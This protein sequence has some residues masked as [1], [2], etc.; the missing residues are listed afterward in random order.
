M[1]Y[2]RIR[3]RV[4]RD[5]CDALTDALEQQNA[6][7]VSIE[8]AGDTPHYDA[9]GCTDPDWQQVTVTGLFPDSVDPAAIERKL[10]DCELTMDASPQID[11]LDEQDWQQVFMTQVEPIQI[12]EQLWIC[13]S[14][15]TPPAPQAT[16]IVLDPG[17]GFGTG[18]HATTALCLQWLA[19]AELAGK[20]VLDYGC[21]SGI[22]ALAAAKL[23]A[24]RVIALDIDPH[25]IRAT[26][27]NVTR[28][29]L[30]EDR[31]QVMTPPELAIDTQG[32]VII[33][34]ILA[35]TLVELAAELS[36]RLTANGTILLTG[37]LNS[38]MVRVRQAYE[39][40]FE[41]I[42]AHREEWC[43]LVG[44]RR[45]GIPVPEYYA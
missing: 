1:A 35:D 17:M 4:A 28:N 31:V 5:Q 24:A 38:Q 39:P 40:N 16:N 20:T 36:G 6:L 26:R 32:D 3:Y 25:A 30:A 34:N 19:Q 41:F 11:T 13:P 18:S 8:D 37:I 43:L 22:L 10:S 21:G 7:A 23:G 45:S 14:W 33:A 9:A 27:D 2:T 44:K 15:I 29:D 12:T 42:C